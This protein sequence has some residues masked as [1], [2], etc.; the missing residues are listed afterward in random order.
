MI[1]KILPILVLLLVFTAPSLALAAQKHTTD[2][3]KIGI[4]SWRGPLG[5]KE[6][7]EPTGKYL[8]ESIGRP[9]TVLPLEF[10]DIL[11]AVKNKAVDFFTADPSMFMSAKIQY[12]A[13]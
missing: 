13:S 9:V 7:W 11:P 1:K 8:T 6:R 2:E 10:K 4:L 5:F 3:V 12:G